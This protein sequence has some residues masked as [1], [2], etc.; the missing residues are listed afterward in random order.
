MPEHNIRETINQAAVC[1]AVTIVGHFPPTDRLFCLCSD[2]SCPTC[3]SIQRLW[4]DRRSET[5]IF[6]NFCP[7]DWLSY[8]KKHDATKTFWSNHIKKVER[9]LKSLWVQRF[10]SRWLQTLSKPSTP[11]AEIFCRIWF[12]HTHITGAA[13]FAVQQRGHKRWCKSYIVEIT[14]LFAARWKWHMRLLDCTLC[15]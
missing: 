3:H 15:W 14:V 5:F 1:C 12:R 8:K 4:L 2:H 7:F 6:N 9:S 11:T 13:L 10:S